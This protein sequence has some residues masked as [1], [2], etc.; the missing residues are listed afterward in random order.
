MIFVFL[1]VCRIYF[2]LLLS[3]LLLLFCRLYCTKQMNFYSPN[4]NML[5]R[6]YQNLSLILI[7][8]NCLMSIQVKVGPKIEP[9]RGFSA[10]PPT[11]KSISSADLQKIRTVTKF[12]T[13]PSIIYF[14]PMKL[15]QRM[16]LRQT[17]INLTTLNHFYQLPLN[18]Y[19]YKLI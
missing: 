9:P 16:K 8:L 1:L 3:F 18:I 11:N 14:Y 4:E 2:G 15:V 6:S 5:F 19:S 17:G 7:F 12:L 13:L 10:N